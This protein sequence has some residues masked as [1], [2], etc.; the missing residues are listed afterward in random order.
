MEQN[1]DITNLGTQRLR[2]IEV[3]LYFDYKQRS[4]GSR[5]VMIYFETLLGVEIKNG[6]TLLQQ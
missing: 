5:Y 6:C 4:F 2:E 1:L 3:P